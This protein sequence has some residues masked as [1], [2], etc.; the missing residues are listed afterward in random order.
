VQDLITLSQ[1][2][3][4]NI[5]MKRKPL[6][7]SRFI[8]DIFEQLE[9][10]AAKRETDMHL[11]CKEGKEYWVL[12]DPNRIGQVLI[13]LIENG[14]KYGHDNGKIVVSLNASKENVQICV[15]DNGPGIADEHQKRIFERFYRIDKSRTKSDKGGTGLGLAIVKQIVEAHNSKIQIES[16][17]GK[18][19]TF[20]F[21]LE[22]TLAV[23]ELLQESDYL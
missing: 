5:K 15:R 16:K 11:D 19:T 12:A 21:K 13:N 22:K 23:P 20:C 9:K 4:G 6:E 17:V 2:E 8:K 14:I 10:K 18:G 1:M 3:N 7:L